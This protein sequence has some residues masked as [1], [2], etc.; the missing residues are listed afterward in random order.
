VQLSQDAIERFVSLTQRG[1]GCWEWLG[2]KD[3]DGYGKMRIGNRKAARAHR[4]AWT[5]AHSDPGKML[6]CHHCDN[7]GCVRPD[8]LFLGTALDNNRDRQSK[9]RPNNAPRGELNTQA[10]LTA[11]QARQVV[12]LYRTGKFRQ[13]DLGE[14]F[15]VTQSAVQLLLSGKN[16]RHS[17][18]EPVTGMRSAPKRSRRKLADQE[19]AALIAEY[20]AGGASQAALAEQYGVSQS[21]VSQAIRAT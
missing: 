15:G 12:E 1:P 17:G 6:V 5:I 16:W 14:M 19:R 20:A 18:I 10:K 3:A 13:R 2:S 7:P 8:H 4:I 21:Y 9:G 11:E